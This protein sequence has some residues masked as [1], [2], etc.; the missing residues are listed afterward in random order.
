MRNDEYYMNIALKEAM[1]AYKEDEVPVGCVKGKTLCGFYK[2]ET[3]DII[4]LDECFI[5]TEYSTNIVKF[6]KN[7][8]TEFGATGYNEKYDKNPPL[9]AEYVSVVKWI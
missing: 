6:V 2:R 4:P 5:Q 1:K 9:W 7:V 8:L 3:H